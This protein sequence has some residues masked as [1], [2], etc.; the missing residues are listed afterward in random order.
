MKMPDYSRSLLSLISSIL[1]HYGVDNGH[2]TLKEMDELLNRNYKNVVLMLFDGMG[3]SILNKHSDVAGFLLKNN[4][5]VISSVFPTTTTA[6]TTTVESGLSPIEHGWLGWAL[7][8]GNID[9]TV[10]LFPN[11]VFR[12]EGMAADYNVAERNLAY[13]SVFEQIE[14]ATSNKVK[15]YEISEFADIKAKNVDE[16][17]ELVENIT[18]ENGEKYIYTYLKQPDYDM[19]NLGTEH[20]KIKNH[21]QKINDRLMQMCDNLQDTLVIITADHGHVDVEWAFLPDYPDIWA[22]LERIPS[23]EARALTFFVKDGKKEEFAYL[24]NKYF[25]NDYELISKDDVIK[26]KLFGEGSPHPL[27]YSFVG[28]YLAVAKGKLALDVSPYREGVFKSAHA[29]TTAEEY[30]IPLIVIDVK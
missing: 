17:C 18:K 10:C 12:G 29:G 30:N 5:A 22:C 3:D 13:K 14:E 7:Y 25:A 20:I 11:T 23:I 2:S 28:D 16:I 4:K 9:K 26:N 24:F 6:A 15:T 19:H 21:I 8:F 1:K 27:A